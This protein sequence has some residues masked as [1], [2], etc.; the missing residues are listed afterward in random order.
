MPGK[1]ARQAP[2][3]AGIIAASELAELAHDLGVE[4]IQLAAR[5]EQ[6]FD[7]AQ[8]AKAL[9]ASL[10][11]IDDKDGSAVKAALTGSGARVCE[12]CSR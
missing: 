3:I 12:A 5:A 2:K 7:Q 8:A 9:N 1:V 11:L 6:L 10:G 4:L